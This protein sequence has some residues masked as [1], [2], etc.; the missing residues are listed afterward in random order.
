M[1]QNNSELAQ[2][3][4]NLLRGNSQAGNFRADVLGNVGALPGIQ[5]AVRYD[6]IGI[7]DFSTREAPYACGGNGRQV[8]P[9]FLEMGHP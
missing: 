2:Q 1:V 9:G 3:I 5:P 4:A 6:R 7:C 8:A